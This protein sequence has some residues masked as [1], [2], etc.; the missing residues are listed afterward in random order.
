MNFFPQALYVATWGNVLYLSLISLLP[1]SM[2]LDTTTIIA[3]RAL[4]I[5]LSI[6][7]LRPYL[8]LMKARWLGKSWLIFVPYLVI[9]LLRLP[10]VYPTYD[11]LAVHFSYGDYANRMWQNN[12]FMPLEFLN[13]F[14]LPYD[15]HY[16]P[17]L[18]LLGIRL[19]IGV[20]YLLTTIWLMSLYL[21]LRELTKNRTQRGLVAILFVAIPFIPHMMAIQGTLMLEY[22]TLPFILEALYQLITKGDKT[23]AIVTMLAAILIKQSHTVFVMPLLLYYGWRERQ[24]VSWKIPI[25]LTLV[26]GIF[27]IRLQ[28]ATGNALS[29]LF[30]GLFASPLYPLTN[31]SQPLFGPKNWGELLVW[32]I[33]GQFT[34]R[35]AEGIVS[36]TAKLFFSPISALPYLLAIYLTIKKKSVKYALVVLSYLIWSKLVGYARY[37]LALNVMVL[38]EM[39]IAEGGRL[40]LT[41]GRR[42]W[43]MVVGAVAVLALSSIKTD[44]SW[45]PNPSLATPAANKY[46]LDKYLEG[47]KLLGRDT[48]RNLAKEYRVLFAPYEAVLTVYR[49]PS[50]MLSYMGY[51]NGL[52]VY[53]T[54]TEDKYQRILASGKID[55]QLKRNLRSADEYRRVLMI[56]DNSFLPYMTEWHTD[57]SYDC[58][59]IGPA[60]ADK[61]LQRPDYYGAT[62]LYDCE[63]RP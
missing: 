53:T 26:A 52:P 7:L 9:P 30:N 28:L 5:V 17:L 14:Y 54:V 48:T 18:G 45:R 55:E 1:S 49:G 56:V 39:I 3:M 31:F 41:L 22:F 34:E 29:G 8:P 27:F 10:L 4:T 63:A 60:P 62:T 2:V 33:W 59:V 16:T 11:D 61:Y 51:L 46:Y 20:F 19:T 23:F 13:Y 47:I 35:Y 24:M 6:I 21:R 42:G 58:R 12:N 57:T 43:I 37:Y 36:Q 15:L 50:T 40:K 25:C 32:P 38:V 44:F